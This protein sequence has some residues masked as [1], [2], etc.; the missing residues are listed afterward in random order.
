[1]SRREYLAAL[2][3]IIDAYKSGRIRVNEM[4]EQTRALTAAYND[5]RGHDWSR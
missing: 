3:T 5:M 4:L 1:M 2:E